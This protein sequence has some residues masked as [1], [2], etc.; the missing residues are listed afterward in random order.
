MKRL[1]IIFLMC[2]G[3]NLYSQSDTVI[4]S[5][6]GGFY[7]NSFDLTLCSNNPENRI[8]YTIN[9]NIPTS[10]SYQY[11]QPLHLD[12]NLYSRSD[13]YKIQMSNVPPYIPDSIQRIIVI[14]AA[15][16]DS[17]GILIS[18]IITN[19]YCIS[20]LGFDNHALPVVSICAD[21][22]ALFN[23]RTGI[24]IPGIYYNPS[25]PEWTGNYYKKGKY[26]ERKC[27]VEYYMHEDTSSLN[28]IAGIRTHGGNSRR[29]QQKGL[30]LY[31]REEYGKKRFKCQV[32]ETS[33][34]NNFKRLVLKPIKC[35]W[36]DA[37]IEDYVCCNI[38]KEINVESLETR[39]CT[40]YINGEYWG[41]YYIQE[42]PDERYLENHF[43]SE[44]EN[45]NVMGDWLSNIV[46]GNSENFRQMMR[47]VDSTDISI[48]ENY[49]QLCEKIDVNCFIDYIIFEIFISN[50]DWPTNNMRCWQEDN[51][52]WRWIFYDGDAT[53]ENL[54][55]DSFSHATDTSDNDWPTN[56]KSTLMFRK[57]LTNRNFCRIF[58]NRF[59]ELCRTAFQYA[60][61]AAYKQQ[62]A[63]EISEEIQNQTNRFNYPQS[64]ESWT[65]ALSN[66][67][68]FL[69]YRP[70][71]II[72]DLEHFIQMSL[73]QNTVDSEIKCFPNPATNF[74]NI[75]VSNTQWGLIRID[76]F[77]LQG[78]T[79]YS[80]I[81]FCDEGENNFTIDLQNFPQGTYIVKVGE[82]IEKVLKIR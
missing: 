52:K 25:N 33:Y 43:Y 61:T 69:M 20:S 47:W 5:A 45:Y 32:F 48:T 7:E 9:G 53:F 40:I 19:S 77:D 11:T 82:K 13:I 41:I 39:P 30:S 78:R 26:W 42:K 59:H 34:I 2:I 57:L 71:K 18:D 6:S 76:I 60:N 10:Q 22:T 3:I 62:I 50:Y 4:F 24:F 73:M 65:E 70:E 16:F 27:N 35:S 1:A 46:S 74:L 68:T 31:A 80:D 56:K 81:I 8:F 67:D 79:V 51:G 75:I 14:R 38:A 29:F 55:Y 21:S 17:N 63:D 72:D 54:D 36:S 66:I 64:Y 37:G 28:Q 15:V 58:S 44:P 49:N 23:N 12:E